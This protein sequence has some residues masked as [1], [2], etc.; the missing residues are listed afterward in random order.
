MIQ[1]PPSSPGPS[2]HGADPIPLSAPPVLGGQGTCRSALLLGAS[3]LVGGEC[4][5]ILLTE[6]SFERVHA[7]V[8]RPLESDH[9]KLIQHLVSFDNL[10]HT[11]PAWLSDAVF[12]CLGTTIRTAGSR[13]AFRRVDYGYPLAAATHAASHNAR[14]F[15]L[16]SA[17]GAQ[18]DSPVFYN[19]IKGEIERDLKGLNFKHLV[20]LRP[21]LILGARKEY[22]RGEAIASAFL[23]PLSGRMTGRLRKYRPIQAR[24]VARAMINISLRT[25]TGITIRESD[26]IEDLGKE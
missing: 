24:T 3:G 15:L 14:V 17:I 26:E 23:K 6:G 1:N 13:E 12:C 22:R 18:P 2:P 5:K 21:A 11:N 20:I 10:E 19:R 8:R 4:L 9:P 16:V 25:T 7:L